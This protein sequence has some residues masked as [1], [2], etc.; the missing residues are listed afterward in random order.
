MSSSPLR[1]RAAAAAFVIVTAGAC[2]GAGADQTV[3]FE[4]HDYAYDGLHVEAKAG[5]KVTFSMRNAGSADHEF[6]VF[7]PD[8]KELGEIEPVSSGK[9]G[10]L[11]LKLTKPGTY[12][13][14]C[15]VSDHEDRGMKGTFEV[16]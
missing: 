13:F 1:T 11:T 6:E 14:V 16:S 9:T 5:E 8:G 3:T 2:S 7:D 15:G 4:A 10:T 12:R